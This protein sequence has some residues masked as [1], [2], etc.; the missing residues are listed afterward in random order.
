[1]Q[2]DSP[3]S[4]SSP[5]VVDSP[6]ASIEPPSPSPTGLDSISQSQIPTTPHVDNNAVT[7]S[8]Q[9][10]TFLGLYTSLSSLR[11]KVR[12]LECEIMETLEVQFDVM[13]EF[14]DQIGNVL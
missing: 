6:P 10:D 5:I 8:Q 9:D 7:T 2:S 14:N 4:D 3:P 12:S 1:M 13:F 11:H